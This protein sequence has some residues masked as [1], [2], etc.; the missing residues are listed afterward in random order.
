MRSDE[1]LHAMFGNEKWQIERVISEVELLS[2]ENIVFFSDEI[3]KHIIPDL[4]EKDSKDLSEGKAVQVV[5]YDEDTK[6]SFNLKLTFQQPFYHLSDTTELFE[7]MELTPGQRIGFSSN[8]KLADTFISF[9]SIS[10]S[11]MESVELCSSDKTV[12]TND[13]GYSIGLELHGDDPLFDKKKVELYFGEFDTQSGLYSTRNELETLNLLLSLVESLPA[14]QMHEQLNVWKDLQC[15]IINKIHEFGNQNK[16]DAEIDRNYICEKEKNLVQWGERNGARTKLEIAYVEGAGRGAVAVEDL[17]I[18]D[19]ALEIPVSI[20]I[21]EELVYKSDMYNILG[22]MDGMSS[23]TML[24]LWSM[25]EKHNCESKFKNYFDT[26]PEEFNTGL[27]FG[28]HAIMA[29]EGTLLLE[30]I[31]QAKEHLRMQYDELFPALCNDYPDIF[32]QE[33]YTWEQFLWACELWYSNSM[34]VM[35]ADGKL[36]TC[37]IPIAGFLNHSLNPHIVRYGKVDSATNTL[38]FPLSR[39][40]SAGEQCCLS[41]GNFSTSHFITFYGFSPQGDNPYD[42]IPIDIDVGQVDCIEDCSMSNWTTHMVWGTWLS[43]NHNIFHYGLP[44]PLLDYLRRVR[45]PTQQEKTLVPANLEIELE[46][47][48]DLESTFSGMLENL[49]DT[50][51]RENTRWDVKLAV[52]FKDVQRRIVSSIITSCSAGRKLVENELSRFMSEG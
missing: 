6:N 33:F 48:E 25:K 50:L 22:K 26:L 51:D 13:D 7:K 28:V 9:G 41:Y 34:K 52:E 29:L 37:L 2:K 44:S 35:L 39:S 19:I 49:G 4:K 40:C 11:S 17:N 14:S 31:M 1:V 23:E 46:V 16:V 10:S 32:P 47:L 15:A 45:N 24:L 3:E 38:K 8:F 30:E 12:D 21:S 43:N 5:V 20:I 36:R 18:G 42:V 27:S